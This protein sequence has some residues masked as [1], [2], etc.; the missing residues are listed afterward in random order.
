MWPVDVL[1]VK[2]LFYDIEALVQR[3]NAVQGSRHHEIL[4][5]V[6]CWCLTEYGDN[7]SLICAHLHFCFALFFSEFEA[8]VHE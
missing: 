3:K 1:K 4:G 6:S 5:S 8:L 2:D 7:V